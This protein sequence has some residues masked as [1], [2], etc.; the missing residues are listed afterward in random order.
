MSI[1]TFP[2]LSLYKEKKSRTYYYWYLWWM[3]AF[4]AFSGGEKISPLSTNLFHLCQCQFL[5]FPICLKTAAACM[6]SC[7]STNDSSSQHCHQIEYQGN[8]VNKQRN[9]SQLFGNPWYFLNMEQTV[10]WLF[11]GYFG[12]LCLVQIV[13]MWGDCPKIWFLHNFWQSTR[14]NCMIDD[15]FLLVWCLPEMCP[16]YKERCSFCLNSISFSLK[17]SETRIGSAVSAILSED[18]ENQIDQKISRNFHCSCM[19]RKM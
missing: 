18:F 5:E 12:Q 16:E 15:L 2:M 7:T 8:H 14:L 9:R 4:C 17:Q 13:I 19:A 11:S 3:G 1:M 6:S 10:W